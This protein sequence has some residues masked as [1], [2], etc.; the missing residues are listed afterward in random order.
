MAKNTTMYARFACI[1]LASSRGHDEVPY[2]DMFENQGV[3]A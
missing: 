1:S 2:A 3:G